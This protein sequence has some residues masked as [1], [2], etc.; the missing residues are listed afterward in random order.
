[1]ITERTQVAIVGAGPAGLLL[2][3]LLQRAGV[4]T[5][6]LE[7]RDRDY[8][9]AR[10]RA[11]VLEQTTV[12]VLHEV[13]LGERLAR[14]GLR[15]GGIHLAFDGARHHIPLDE[16]T[17]GRAVTVYG[18]TEVVRDL[19]AAR[20]A[21]D[22]P[23]VFGASEVSIHGFEDGA[24]APA[25]RYR[26]DGVEHELGADLIAGCDG[27]HGICRATVAPAITAWERAYGFAWLGILVDAPP[28]TDELIY[29]RHPRG[30]AL[31]SMRSSS[32]S[33]LYLQVDPEARLEDWSEDRIWSELRARLTTEDGVAPNEGR[34]TEKSITPMRSFVAAPMRHGRLFLAGDAAHIVPPTGAK[35]LNLAVADVT[36]L[37]AAVAAHYDAGDDA[38]LASYSERCLARVWRAQRFSWWMTTML[39]TDPSE[40]AYGE[41]LALAQLREVVSSRAQATA[42]AE[43][44]VGLPLLGTRPGERTVADPV[45]SGVTDG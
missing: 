26:H 32:V 17:G 13:G 1:M 14:E 35:G 24:G 23:L 6:I 10:V 43:N 3:R 7:V 29:A 33:R 15:H 28:A 37:A 21:D 45:G 31:Y 11:G 9:E 22:E 30:F 16:L 38:Q 20:V 41:Q 39:H 4:E 19:V 2:G 36:V 8:V 44:Y 12:D 40:D 42:L 34:V 18:Q 5:V 27:F 25:V